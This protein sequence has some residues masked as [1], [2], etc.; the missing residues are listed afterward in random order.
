MEV[1]DGVRRDGCEHQLS[2]EEVKWLSSAV[3][4]GSADCGVL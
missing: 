3:S 2:D 4:L 1:E